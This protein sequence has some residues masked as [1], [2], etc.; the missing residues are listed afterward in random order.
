M[1]VGEMG[2]IRIVGVRKQEENDHS[3]NGPKTEAGFYSLGWALLFW[4]AISLLPD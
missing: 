1:K 4:S 3:K 2:M